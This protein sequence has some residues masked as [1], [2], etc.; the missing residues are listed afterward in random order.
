MKRFLR[1]TTAKFLAWFRNEGRRFALF[2]MAVIVAASG[3]LAAGAQVTHAQD[4]SQYGDATGRATQGINGT[5]IEKDS[6]YSQGATQAKEKV[7]SAT[8]SVFSFILLFIGRILQVLVG[9]VSQLLVF[10]IGIFLS[11]ASYNDFVTSAAVIRGWSVVRD[12]TNLFFVIALLAISF[13]TLFGHAKYNYKNGAIN[14]LL[15]AAI[16][17]NFSRT[18]VGVLVDFS[19]VVMLTFVIG[20]KEIAAGNIADMFKLNKIMDIK[21][22]TDTVSQ[23]TGVEIA[24]NIV[25]SLLLGLFMLLISFAAIVYMTVSLL[26]RAV[27]IWMLTVVSPMAFFLRAVPGQEGAFGK[28]W[29]MLM[30]QLVYGPLAAF[31]LWL[32]FATVS[33]NQQMQ[34]MAAPNVNAV[35]AAQ[36]KAWDGSEMLSFML[37]TIMLIYGLRL[38]EQMA[39]DTGKRAKGLVSSAKHVGT[40]LAKSAGSLALN[41]PIWRSGGQN[42]SLASMGKAGAQYMGDTKLAKTIKGSTLFSEDARKAKLAKSDLAALRA[43]GQYDAASAL[44]KKMI[45]EGVATMDK[46]KYK[47]DQLKKIMNDSGASQMERQQA[48]LALAKKGDDSLK[49]KGAALK[50]MVGSVGGSSDFEKMVRAALKEKGDEDAMIE[51]PDDA[52]KLIEKM[53][54]TRKKAEFFNGIND[55]AQPTVDGKLKR[56]AVSDYL[57]A[58]DKKSYDEN[59][60]KGKPIFKDKVKKDV[61]SALVL[62]AN[63]EKDA[64]KKAA[65]ADKYLELT[66][67]ALTKAISDPIVSK[68]EGKRVEARVGVAKA[69]KFAAPPIDRAAGQLLANSGQGEGLVQ[70]LRNLQAKVAGGMT[71]AQAKAEI[72]NIQ[73]ALSAAALKANDQSEI[74]LTDENGAAIAND[75]IV[76]KSSIAKDIDAIASN[77]AIDAKEIEN[78][79]K[80]ATLAMEEAMGASTWFGKLDPKARAAVDRTFSTGRTGLSAAKNGFDAAAG[81]GTDEE[82]MIAIRKAASQGQGAASRLVKE[83]GDMLSQEVHDSLQNLQDRLRDLKKVKTFSPTVAAEAASIKSQIE[84]LTKQV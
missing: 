43:T 18:I 27:K 61:E 52:K 65:L 48:M 22:T 12:V 39:G 36:S 60:S 84:K 66:G 55:D 59:D 10:M 33:G 8:S 70:D 56:E 69:G 31:F 24:F 80:A 21:P 19:Q 3:F 7:A 32:T 47:P 9:F 76:F 75:E 77:P 45:E 53:Y 82:K 79:L 30:E 28:W 74:G 1:Q 50:G 51:K 11:A 44:E 62:A 2:G 58:L 46:K 15:I 63:Y 64:K 13:G 41:A 72:G 6:A 57:L 73:I 5:P 29:G 42:I 20:F 16:I 14:K 23:D 71:A 78:R 17:I 35:G 54:D 68:A 40:R 38:A 67:Q 81:I 4:A 83:A 49:G 37:A 25:V 34:G 26:V